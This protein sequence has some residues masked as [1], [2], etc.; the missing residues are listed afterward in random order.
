MF[1]LCV[2]LSIYSYC[3]HCDPLHRSFD[4]RIYCYWCVRAAELSWSKWG[5]GAIKVGKIGKVFGIWSVACGYTLLYLISHANWQHLLALQL[6]LVGDLLFCTCIYF[7]I[8]LFMVYRA[9][10]TRLLWQIEVKNFLNYYLIGVLSA[11]IS[12]FNGVICFCG[13]AVTISSW[14]IF[15]KIYNDLHKLDA[16]NVLIWLPMWINYLQ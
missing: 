5:I 11:H 4:E 10:S 2:M 1:D 8:G 6:Q 16:I 15:T 9:G 3:A 13:G 12:T 14:S 7:S